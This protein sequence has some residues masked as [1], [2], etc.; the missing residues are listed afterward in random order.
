[1]KSDKYKGC[2]IEF[3]ND[4]QLFNEYGKIG[5]TEYILNNGVA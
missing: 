2:L 5:V 3:M 4:I 1:M